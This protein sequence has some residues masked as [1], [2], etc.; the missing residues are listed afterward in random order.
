MTTHTGNVNGGCEAQS[1][2]AVYRAI[3]WLE[4]YVSSNPHSD[5]AM[6]VRN[7]IRELHGMRLRPT[8][9]DVFVLLG[10]IATSAGLQQAPDRPKGHMDKRMNEHAKNNL[11]F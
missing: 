4:N 1:R 6:E 8:V 3:D 5:A 7:I 9:E 2:A 10:Q 11:A